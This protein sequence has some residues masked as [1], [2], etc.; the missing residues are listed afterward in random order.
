VEE[1]EEEAV[2]VLNIDLPLQGIIHL[3]NNKTVNI[4]VQIYQDDSVIL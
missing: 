3:R 4:H 2:G 1:E